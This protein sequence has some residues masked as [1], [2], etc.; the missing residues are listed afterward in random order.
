MKP[1]YHVAMLKIRLAQY[2]LATT[3]ALSICNPSALADK[4][5]IGMTIDNWNCARL[6]VPD[7]PA[8]RAGIVPGDKIVAVNNVDVR[9]KTRKQVAAL[10]AGPSGTQVSITILRAGKHFRCNLKRS[11]SEKTAKTAALAELDRHE[12][13]SGVFTGL[14]IDDS[15]RVAAVYEYSPAWTAGLRPGDRILYVNDRQMRYPY[16]TTLA[17]ILVNPGGA[18]LHLKVSRGDKEYEINII[19]GPKPKV[20]HK[21]LTLSSSSSSTDKAHKETSP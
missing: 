14:E 8:Q 21:K 17:D 6:V 18:A 20:L 4:G 11:L 3:V 5:F 19:A 13:L 15:N 9:N 16:A 2:F 1:M 12:H 10:I 7:S